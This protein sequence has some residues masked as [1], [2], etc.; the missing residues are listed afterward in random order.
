MWILSSPQDSKLQVMLCA[1][2]DSMS[3]EIARSWVKDLAT[4][5]TIFASQ[6]EILLDDVH[7]EVERSKYDLSR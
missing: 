4:A 1:S 7:V 6:P 3:L 2:E 5:V